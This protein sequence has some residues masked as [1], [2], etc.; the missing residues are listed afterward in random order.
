[1]NKNLLL[2][3]FTAIIAGLSHGMLI[4]DKTSGNVLFDS[5]GFEM[6]AVGKQPVYAKP[7]VIRSKSQD[8]VFGPDSGGPGA[9]KGSKYAFT[10]RNDSG[11][12]NI[13][14]RFKQA[15]A[16]KGTV[17]DYEWAW[18]MPSG[19]DA[20]WGLIGGSAYYKS[21]WRAAGGHIRVIVDGKWESRGRYVPNEW[22]IC[23]L[24]YTVGDRTAT[25]TVGESE[26]QLEVDN[27]AGGSSDIVG[28][29]F[30]NNA[31]GYY[32]DST[33]DSA[34]NEQAAEL[35]P[36]NVQNSNVS[37]RPD[38]QEILKIS[39]AKLPNTPRGIQWPGVGMIGNKFISVGGWCSGEETDS[40]PGIY[41]RGFFNDVFAMDVEK[42]S[43]GW[44]RLPDFPGAERMGMVSVAVNDKLYLWGGL[45]Y[46]EPYCYT[47]GYVLEKSGTDWQWSALP[48]LPH[49]VVFAGS[50]AIG[51]KI[52]VFGGCDYDRKMFFTE[53][54][55]SGGT[56]G[57]GR[58][59]IV[60][61]TQNQSEGWKQ[62]TPCPGTA[63][64]NVAAA[65]IDGKIYIMGGATGRDSAN[66]KI[67]TVVDNWRY[68]PE[69]DRWTRLKDLPIASG[70][71][72]TGEI[73]YDNRYLLLIGGAQ[74]ATIQYPDGRVEKSES[75]GLAKMFFPKYL[76]ESWVGRPQ[77]YTSDIFVYDTHT[78][79]F[80]E[81]TMLPFNNNMMKVVVRGDKL[82]LMSGETGGA[83]MGG[84]YYGHHPDFFVVGTIQKAGK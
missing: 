63:R 51:S 31:G 33:S 16:A 46:T 53:N 50:C 18:Y 10:S 60:F 11:S 57:L 35:P 81:A 30:A 76:K 54:D 7:G 68:E 65:S 13:E 26:M 58:S 82:Y 5:N 8:S 77:R 72:P 70:S 19:A 74:F 84:E 83:V 52:Y 39:W 20:K 49:P 12:G 56:P 29:F 67:N 69:G 6:D 37:S 15:V 24:T 79:S 47:D 3:L 32:I 73:V 4:T 42:T 36:G 64:L 40:K 27:H 9:F 28:L 43:Q 80:A 59:L 78:D 17:L 14:L 71:F 61:D 2:S 41:P 1:M 38:L 23:R 66:E 21:L 22:L 45:S 25:L 75:W 48:P 44:V 34:L 62:L 55:R